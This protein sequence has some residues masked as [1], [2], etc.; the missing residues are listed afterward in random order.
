M[1]IPIVKFCPLFQ[2]VI[3]LFIVVMNWFQMNVKVVS[4]NILSIMDYF[5]KASKQFEKLF[6]MMFIE[7]LNFSYPQLFF[8]LI[9][10]V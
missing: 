5:L 7:R 2:K 1:L 3:I 8:S 6:K 10:L 4:R 9:T